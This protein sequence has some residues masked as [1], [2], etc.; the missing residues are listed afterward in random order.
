[1]TLTFD[2]NLYYYDN[3]NLKTVDRGL[4]GNSRRE[5]N[6]ISLATIG[7]SSA[8]SRFMVASAGQAAQ[9]NV[10]TSTIILSL[11]SA[12]SGDYITFPVQLCD[13]YGNRNQYV[14]QVTLNVTPKNNGIDPAT[15]RPIVTHEPTISI[16]NSWD[17]RTSS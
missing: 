17:G 3:G 15:Q 8:P 1:M 2:S 10:P 16:S 5:A 14:L 4:P 7:T 9:V 6:F 11:V 13:Q 12:M